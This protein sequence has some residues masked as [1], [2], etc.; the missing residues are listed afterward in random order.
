[1]NRFFV[2]ITQSS[3]LK[4]DQGSLSVTLEIFLKNLFFTRVLIRLEK[5]MKAVKIFFQTSNRG[6]RAASYLS[7]DGSKATPVRDIFA[8]MLKVTMDIHHSL[9]TKIINL[10][11]ENGCFPEDLKLTEVSPVSKKKNDLDKENYRPVKVLLNVLKVLERIMCSR[12]DAFMQDKLSNLITR[13]RKN[14]NTQYC[15]IYIFEIW[16]IMLDKGGMHALCSW[17]YQRPFDT[18]HHNLMTTKLGAHGFSQDA[19]QYMRSYL[20]NTQQR[21]RVNSNFSSSES[22]ITEVP[23]G[24]RLKIR[25]IVIQRPYQ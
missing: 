21:V 22:I 18:I 8:D 9:I 11:F 25:T 17:T 6:T 5:L 15:L 13:L 20:T 3:N 10:S 2:N 12:I 16:K 1:M 24:S 23:Q 7:I 4:E 19:L 14:H